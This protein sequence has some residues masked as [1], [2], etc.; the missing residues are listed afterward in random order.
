MVAYTGKTAGADT[1]RPV[2]MPEPLR[3]EE[4]VNGL[5]AR[6]GLKVMQKISTIADIWRIDDEW[7]RSE[8]VSRT[9]FAVILVSGQRL[10]VFKD[11]AGGKWY[12][13]SYY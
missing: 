1:F 5:P 3:V 6:V 12:R 13:Q 7:W 10:V 9:Y 2:N 4:D 8:A 11:L